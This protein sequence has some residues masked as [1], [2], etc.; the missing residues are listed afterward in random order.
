MSAGDS[1]VPAP[2]QLR[3]WGSAT[4]SMP[5]GARVR[6]ARQFRAWSQARLARAV[7]IDQ[8][9]ISRI[10]RGTMVPSLEDL[11]A[12]SQALDV[13]LTELL[14]S[15]P[16]RPQ[17]HCRGDH[18]ADLSASRA[19]AR[20]VPEHL[21]N[22]FA[23]A[24]GSLTELR[25]ARTGRRPLGA[26]AVAILASLGVGHHQSTSASRRRAVCRSL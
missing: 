5:V 22:E 4:P 10:E 9:S 13:A 1:A 23:R 8:S 11:E 3:L 17:L 18:R 16:A 15:A 14:G 26:G 7:G 2:G 25:L 19:F 12:M 6:G 20:A 21:F 24:G